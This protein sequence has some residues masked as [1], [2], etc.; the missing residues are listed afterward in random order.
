MRVLYRGAVFRVAQIWRLG[1]KVRV[2][3]IH[4][5]IKDIYLDLAPSAK[6]EVV[7]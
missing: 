1:K 5:M 7:K 4:P 3:L 6:V 2:R